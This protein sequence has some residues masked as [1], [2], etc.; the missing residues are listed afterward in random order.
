MMLFV[1]FIYFPLHY[2]SIDKTLLRHYLFA[3]RGNAG[4]LLGLYVHPGWPK[5]RID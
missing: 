3:E 5:P 1:S 2:V 4:Q